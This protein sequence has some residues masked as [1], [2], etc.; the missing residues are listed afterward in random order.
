MEGENRLKQDSETR[1]KRDAAVEAR[2]PTAR[3]HPTLPL[4]IYN[5][6]PQTAFEKAWD[7][8]TLAHRG[9]V[10]DEE[11]CIV[12][13]CLPKFFHLSEHQEGKHL[14]PIPAEPFEVME[15]LDGSYIGA[16]IYQGQPVVWSRGSFDSPQATL[17]AKLL[18]PVAIDA[19]R[20]SP[21]TFIFELI[22]PTHRVVLPYDVDELVLLAILDEAGQPEDVRQA[23]LPGIRS[24][25][26][27]PPASP[28]ALMAHNRPGAE[29]FVLR[30]ASGLMAKVKH[31]NYVR[32][33]RTVIGLGWRRVF[34]AIRDG[35]TGKLLDAVP[36]EWHDWFQQ[37]QGE[38]ETV[39]GEIRREIDADWARLEPL[40]NDRRAFAAAV[41]SES[42]DLR[43]L[44]FARLDGRELTD[45][46]WQSAER[47]L[48]GRLD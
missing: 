43:G 9:L 30:F 44:L 24:V 25:T 48:E 11:G 6:T 40:A 46:I 34:E 10:V 8:I 35:S 4:A 45:R 28:E 13:Q 21:A 1:S 14:P 19:M 33:H 32:L 12:G 36:D 17:A 22:G 47:R 29:G 42:A 38:V 26:F 39:V 2:R 31:D 20:S 23:A 15:K 3:R 37:V 18:P 16:T 41:S 7:A 27:H 5:Y